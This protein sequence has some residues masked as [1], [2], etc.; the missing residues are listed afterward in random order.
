MMTSAVQFDIRHQILF[1]RGINAKIQASSQAKLLI[2]HGKQR[3]IFA[4]AGDG[5][6]RKLVDN[7]AQRKMK[8]CK[9]YR[10]DLRV[11]ALKITWRV[12]KWINPF[13][14][15]LLVYWRIMLWAERLASTFHSCPWNL[16]LFQTIFQ[17]WALSSNIPA[18]EMGLFTQY[19]H[20][21]ADR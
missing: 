9:I 16:S 14:A 19:P 1:W 10:N 17:P 7:S 12:L 3:N 6:I 20:Q 11:L 4:E 2:G 8:I 13:P 18:A 5:E 15:C 21:T